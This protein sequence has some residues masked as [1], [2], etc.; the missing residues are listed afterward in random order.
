M[1]QAD[2][3]M[4]NTFIASDIIAP[5]HPK[6]R[7]VSSNSSLKWNLHALILIAHWI[8]GPAIGMIH[9]RRDKSRLHLWIGISRDFRQC[10]FDLLVKCNQFLLVLNISI[11]DHGLTQIL[12][13]VTTWADTEVACL[14]RALLCPHTCLGCWTRIPLFWTKRILKWERSQSPRPWLSDCKRLLRVLSP[15]SAGKSSPFVFFARTR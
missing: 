9:C 5:H 2:H 6:V 15:M 11:H 4:C 7:R 8:P 10:L 12:F 14:C 3:S 1:V 13:T